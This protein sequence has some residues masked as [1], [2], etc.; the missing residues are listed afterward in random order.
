MLVDGLVRYGVSEVGAVAL[1]IPTFKG[2]ESA[3]IKL[4]PKL[5]FFLFC[6][7]CF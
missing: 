7:F 3:E 1:I 4:S 5:C 2:T 6:L